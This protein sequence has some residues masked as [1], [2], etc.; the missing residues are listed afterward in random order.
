M[1]PTPYWSAWIDGR[2]SRVPDDLT[3]YGSEREVWAVAA[4]DALLA[5][6]ELH[7]MRLDRGADAGVRA[8]GEVTMEG[9][10]ELRR[11]DPKAFAA[12]VSHLLGL[13]MP[14]TIDYDAYAAWRRRNDE[15]GG[16]DG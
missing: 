1:N 16:I 5:A 9:L 2:C 11:H 14:P 4:I 3:G 15:G 10:R 8:L 6:A 13:A 7:V 12:H